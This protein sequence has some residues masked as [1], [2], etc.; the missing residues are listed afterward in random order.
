MGKNVA[1]KHRV[2]NERKKVERKRRTSFGVHLVFRALETYDAED[3]EPDEDG[4]LEY[5]PDHRP[6][7]TPHPVRNHGQRRARGEDVPCALIR[8]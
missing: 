2:S 5:D 1:N 7:C 4:D 3:D 8:G 6:Y